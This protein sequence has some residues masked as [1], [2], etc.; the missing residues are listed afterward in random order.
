MEAGTSARSSAVEREGEELA[1][2]E[3]ERVA[4]AW[5]GPGGPGSDGRQQRSEQDLAG[6]ST[7]NSAAG[8]VTAVQIWHGTAGHTDTG[9]ST[10]ASS[11]ASST[12]GCDSCPSSCCRHTGVSRGE[13]VGWVLVVGAQFSLRL[14]ARTV[15][16]HLLHPSPTRA[17]IRKSCS[18][19]SAL[20]SPA[21]CLQGLQIGPVSCCGPAH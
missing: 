6:Q 9:E 2:P 1:R 7:P 3:R 12:S 15:T 14:P 11:S 21:P 4:E 16:R 19:S 13:G 20:L 10:A 18:P 5:S 17:V 8:S